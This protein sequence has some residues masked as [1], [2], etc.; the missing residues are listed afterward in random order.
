MTHCA[1]VA[2]TDD[3]TGAHRTNGLERV[4]GR[5]PVRPPLSAPGTPDQVNLLAF[6]LPACLLGRPAQGGATVRVAM[7]RRRHR[8]SRPGPPTTLHRNRLDH[9]YDDGVVLCSRPQKLWPGLNSNWM[10]R[11]SAQGLNPGGAWDLRLRH[12][13]PAPRPCHSPA[14]VGPGRWTPAVSASYLQSQW[15]FL[16]SFEGRLCFPHAPPLGDP[17]VRIDRMADELGRAVCWSW[18]A[19]GS[20]GSAASV[21]MST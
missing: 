1:T 21:S 4:W 12:L 2:A 7:T 5:T 19:G 10:L 13:K 6:P 20:G 17:A 8:P 3:M 14:V 11:L 15:L 18:S 16:K 9:F